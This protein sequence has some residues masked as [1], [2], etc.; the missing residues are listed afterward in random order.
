MQS[1]TTE[2]K[3]NLRLLRNSKEYFSLDKLIQIRINNLREQTIESCI[4]RV[5]NDAIKCADQQ[6]ILWELLEEINLYNKD[7]EE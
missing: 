3:E 1:I 4:S 7:E 5:S 2:D 6:Q